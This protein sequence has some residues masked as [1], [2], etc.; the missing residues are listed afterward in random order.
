MNNFT[1]FITGI[2]IAISAGILMGFAW[3]GFP[4]AMD[5]IMTAECHTLRIQAKQYDD[6]YLTDWQEAQCSAM[7]VEINLNRSWTSPSL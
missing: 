6:Y 2:L 1:T 3:Y 5:R 4:K 7:N